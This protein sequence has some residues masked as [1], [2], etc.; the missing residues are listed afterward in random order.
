MNN[1]INGS[2]R[3]EQSN[4]ISRWENEGGA[5]GHEALENSSVRHLYVDRSWAVYR[6]P[7]A[8]AGRR[9]RRSDKALGLNAVLSPDLRN[10]TDHKKRRLNRS[11]PNLPS[12]KEP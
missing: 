2:R 11:H 10:M 5:P 12:A 1:D 9:Q 8:I 3:R 6:V 7:A 4:A